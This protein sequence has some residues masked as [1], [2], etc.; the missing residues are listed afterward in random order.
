MDAA[1]LEHNMP[2]KIDALVRELMPQLLAGD[3]PDHERLRTQ[4]E[5]ASIAVEDATGTGYFIAFYVPNDA[6]LANP[7]VAHG[8]PAADGFLESDALGDAGAI[9]WLNQGRLSGLE[10][11]AT[12]P[13]PPDLPVRV[14]GA[15]PWHGSV[16]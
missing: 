6:P 12:D 8:G 15:R 4:Y 10:L 3:T 5:C 2:P 16:H 7:E 9:L 11:Y 1:L 14:T 13:W